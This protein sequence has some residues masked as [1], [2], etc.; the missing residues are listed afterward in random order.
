MYQKGSAMDIRG[1]GGGVGSLLLTEV[2][3][4]SLVVYNEI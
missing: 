2:S 3:S 1:D 4:I